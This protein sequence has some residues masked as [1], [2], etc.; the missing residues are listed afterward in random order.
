M[1]VTELCRQLANT[2]WLPNP[3]QKYLNNS[4]GNEAKLNLAWV[5]AGRPDKIGQAFFDNSQTC[6]AWYMAGEVI[7]QRIEG[8]QVGE[9]ATLLSP[10]DFLALVERHPKVFR[11]FMPISTWQKAFK[12]K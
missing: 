6:A 4:H 12:P 2:S 1:N 5:L 3:T 10:A 7:K 8:I 9:Y 11:Q